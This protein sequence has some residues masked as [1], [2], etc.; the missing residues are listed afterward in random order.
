[1]VKGQIKIDE[2]AFVLLAGIVLIAVLMVFWTTPTEAPP[3]VDVSSKTVTVLTGG[4]TSFPMTI[5]GPITNVSVSAYGTISNWIS[6]SSEYF[7][8]INESQVV[9]VYVK[10][11]SNIA[12]GTYKGV[13]KVSSTGG[14]KDI[15]LTVNVQNIT[16]VEF[17][18][19]E[20]SL[21]DFSLSLIESRTFTFTPSQ[22]EVVKGY[23]AEYNLDDLVWKINE[24]EIENVA[25]ATIKLIV[26]DTNKLGNLI[27]ELNG[28]EIYNRPAELGE[29]VIPV[30]VSELKPSNV[31]RI[32]AGNPGWMFWANTVHKIKEVSFFVRF[33][34][35][36][37][38][39][40]YL[41]LTKQ[42]VS[43][44]NHI[45]I[46]S[47]V[48]Y[49]QPIILRIK[50]ND[51]TVYLKRSPEER[52]NLWI[53]KDILDNRLIL[54]VGTNKITFILESPGNVIFRNAILSYNYLPS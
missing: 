48:E 34:G 32:R 39:E 26:S 19:E 5:S 51:Q 50:V 4:S 35:M 22:P 47:E 36:N 15:Q 31:V 53:N 3:T 54:N 16:T 25:E 40:A 8:Y 52:L 13:I 44:F 29:I 43:G 11:P 38:K 33:K 49:D 6:F 42:Q 28:K 21:G 14:S 7:D 37:I 30:N 24:T 41:N 17:L 46:V 12:L 27:V 10:A 1:M 18:K 45:K 9:V 2:F 23:F 20:V